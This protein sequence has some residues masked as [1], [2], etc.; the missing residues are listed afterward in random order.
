VLVEVDRATRLARLSARG[1]D[2]GWQSRWES[3]EA[4]YFSTLR[5]PETFDAL[6]PGR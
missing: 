5:P 1:D 6:V 2:S 4:Y 3:A